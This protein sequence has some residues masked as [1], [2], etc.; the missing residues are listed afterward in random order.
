MRITWEV[1][2][3]LMDGMCFALC[4][5]IEGPVDVKDIQEMTR[6]LFH[7]Y[8]EIEGITEVEVTEEGE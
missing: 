8:C 1:A 2:S 6:G 7:K 4:Q 3:A 5:T